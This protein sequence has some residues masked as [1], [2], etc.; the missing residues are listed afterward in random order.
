MLASKNTLA[1]SAV[2]MMSTNKIVTTFISDDFLV[3]INGSC[4]L[5]FIFRTKIS[6]Y[7]WCTRSSRCQSSVSLTGRHKTKQ[8]SEETT[9]NVEH[10][11]N[12]IS[13]EQHQH[14]R[15]MRPVRRKKESPR[16]GAPAR[17]REGP[18]KVS[19]WLG[20]ENSLK[21]VLPLTHFVS[22]SREY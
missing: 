11:T 8:F 21:K 18:Q 16:K 5:C 10:V 15:G 4:W 7:G 3:A 2:A 19:S 17:S 12:A 9:R 1:I 14:F 22:L 20:E 13:A 6:H